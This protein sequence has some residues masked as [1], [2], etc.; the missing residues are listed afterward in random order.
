M[1]IIAALLPVK[2]LAVVWSAS[3]LVFALETLLPGPRFNQRP[4]HC[5]VLIRHQA[6]CLSLDLLEESLRHVLIQQPVPV[7]AVHRRVPYSIINLQANKPAKQQV[8]IELL[9]EQVFAAD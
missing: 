5:E 2:I 6:Y 8:V 9:H 3:A 7:L 4:I 1:S